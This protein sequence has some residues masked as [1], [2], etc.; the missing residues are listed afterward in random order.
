MV[1]LPLT[2]TSRTNES[3][4][5]FTDGSEV[6]PG[7]PRIIDVVLSFVGLVGSLPLLAVLGLLILCSSPGTVLFK[8]QRVGR[9]GTLF[10]LYKL[11]TMHAARVGPQVTSLGDARITRIGRFLR[12]TKLDELPTLWNVL[13]GDMS[14]VGPRPEVPKYVDLDNPEWRLVLKAKPGI[15]DPVTLELK[16]EEK[17]L[18]EIGGDTE[19]SYLTKLQPLK[20]RGYVAYLKN[21]TWQSD[22]R[23]LWQTAVAVI[24]SRE[25]PSAALTVL[26]NDRDEQIGGRNRSNQ[27]LSR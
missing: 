24:L 4:E 2:Q 7:F 25:S 9:N 22:M 11:R 10:T 19:E 16:N 13:R 26:S 3:V 18:A 6:E 23:V 1:T 15:T 8:Q 20:L 5:G 21:R 27:K 12:H 14:L 17:L